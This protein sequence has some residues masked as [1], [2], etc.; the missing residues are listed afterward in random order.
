M[1]AGKC[2]LVIDV[3]TPPPS[4]LPGS[5]EKPIDVAD[6]PPR[7]QRPARTFH[8]FFARYSPLKKNNR[9]HITQVS[10]N[11][12]PSLK[13]IDPPWPNAFSQHVKGPQTSFQSSDLP[14]FAKRDKDTAS[15]SVICSADFRISNKTDSKSSRLSPNSLHIQVTNLLERDKII[16]S[17]PEEHRSHPGI[18]RFL[19]FNENSSPE[20]D[21][22][23]HKWRPRQAAEVLGNE[24]Q[25]LHLRSWLQALTI[26]SPTDPQATASQSGPSGSKDNKGLKRPKVIRSVV[27]EGPRKRRRKDSDEESDGW[28]VDDDET[29][30][31][32]GA[33]SE[34]NASIDRSLSGSARSEKAFRPREYSKPGI[35]GPQVIKQP[36]VPE[37]D[38]LTNTI[39]LVG[40]PGSGKT[41][42]VYAC[43]D[44]LGWEVFEVYPGIGK[45]SGAGISSLIGDVGK[46]HLVR[47]KVISALFSRNNYDRVSSSRLYPA[48]I[49]RIEHEIPLVRQ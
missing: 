35:E 31:S 45:R 42:T 15:S 27:K 14:K 5:Q 17:L 39:L 36:Q 18:S 21:I 40:P 48:R 38:T 19:N 3:Q 1:P 22:W 25:A 11:V 4:K 23:T 9:D 49:L 8:P 12:K 29:E 20:T 16:Q 43:A 26:L 46:N 7:E 41:S 28:I 44:E 10:R 32:G 6:S 34:D 33:A 2:T 13:P 47:R 24:C 37:P 30:E